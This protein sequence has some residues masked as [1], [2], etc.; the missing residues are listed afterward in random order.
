[1]LNKIAP[2]SANPFMKTAAK[3]A[4][5]KYFATSTGLKAALG[6]STCA[7][8]NRILRRSNQPYIPIPGY[9]P[10]S[11]CESI[12]QYDSVTSAP[13][14]K[15]RSEQHIQQCLSRSSLF[16]STRDSI[17]EIPTKTLSLRCDSRQTNDGRIQTAFTSSFKAG[18][19]NNLMSELRN[20]RR[21]GNKK[22]FDELGNESSLPMEIAK[23][24][25]SALDQSSSEK[26]ELHRVNSDLATIASA[27]TNRSIIHAYVSGDRKRERM[28]HTASSAMPTAKLE[29]FTE[30]NSRDGSDLRQT[31]LTLIENAGAAPSGT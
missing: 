2:G 1:M 12:H 17:M 5:I 6:T 4:K 31:T 16:Q 24:A 28:L 19:R 11:A 20:R 10:K 9:A 7:D 13:L 3:D 14:N 27:C 21:L 30:V 8:V 15:S 29:P 18:E 26:A 25:H 23:N 22:W